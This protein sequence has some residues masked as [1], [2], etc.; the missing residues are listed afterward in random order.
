MDNLA[1]SQSLLRVNLGCGQS[2][3]YGWLN[4]DASPSVQLAKI[5]RLLSIPPWSI[6]W[7][8]S[9][10]QLD[11]IRFAHDNHIAYGNGAKG[12]PI[13]TG[14][15]DIV[16]ASHVIEHLTVH[17]LKLFLKEI[18][19]ILT[20]GGILR[21]A[22][23]DLQIYIDT[24]QSDRDANKFVQSLNVI[25]ANHPNRLH[26]WLASL[27]GNRTLHRWVYNDASLIQTLVNHG[28]VNP[29]KL[30]PGETT[31]PDPGPLNLR[32]RAWESLYVEVIKPNHIS[33][34]QPK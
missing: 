24:Y 26:R 2:P 1:K 5:L 12:L 3:T 22:V 15:C 28:F 19:R 20:P 32:E 16:Y 33:H 6:N 8:L 7:L 14:S 23:P 27:T 4:F 9:R 25:P 34:N 11:F 31:I 21:I 18:F 17:E 30:L 29:Q 10:E 13:P